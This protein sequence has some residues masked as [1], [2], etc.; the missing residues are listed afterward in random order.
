MRTSPHILILASVLA[1]GA[2]S[3]AA[4]APTPKSAETTSAGSAATSKA[5]NENAKLDA[6]F[7]EQFLASVRAYPQRLT[8][9]GM[10]ERQDEWNDN[11]LSLIH[12]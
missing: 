4:D 8:S 7:Q 1:F 12:I 9:L 6:W 3:P 2:C 5:E 10:D 11:S